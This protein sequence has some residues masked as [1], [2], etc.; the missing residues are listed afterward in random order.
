LEEL[1]FSS[2]TEA[3]AAIAGAVQERRPFSLVRL[4]DGEGNFLANQLLPGNK[5]L[6]EQNR[7]ILRNWF[8]ET[9]ELDISYSELFDDLCRAIENADVLGLP[10]KSRVG[11][12]STNVCRGFWGIYFSALHVINLKR[13]PRILTTSVVHL[14][15]FRNDGFL[16]ALRSA[17][18]IHTISCHRGFGTVVRGKFGIS[19]GVDIV[20]PGE[21]G[22]PEIPVESKRGTHYP[23]V[24][25]A[26]LRGISELSPGSV[27]LIAAGVC[28][29]VYARAA[30][31]AG[32]AGIDIGAMADHIMGLKTRTIFRTSAF[33]QAPVNA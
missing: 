25:Q 19:L 11:F 10:Q 24:Y 1:P 12:E 22:I 33:Q 15:L 5:F 20:V 23:E 8:G 2:S 16:A 14:D 31:D 30:K 26:V 21:M 9:A 18:E 17:R 29:K 28:G 32:C 3:I 7:K 13:R 6:A 4:G 27:V